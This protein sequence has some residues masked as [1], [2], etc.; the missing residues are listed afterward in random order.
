MSPRAPLSPFWRVVGRGLTRH[1]F[2]LAA[3]VG[4]CGRGRVQGFGAAAK[5]ACATSLP[6]VIVTSWRSQLLLAVA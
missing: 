6:R 1:P 2:V 4:G 5:V 3:V